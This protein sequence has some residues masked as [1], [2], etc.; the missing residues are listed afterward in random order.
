MKINKLSTLFH[1]NIKTKVFYSEAKLS[2]F[3]SYVLCA[4]MYDCWLLK[5]KIQKIDSRRAIHWVIWACASVCACDRTPLLTRP[6]IL[7]IAPMSTTY[8]G[9]ILLNSTVME[10]RASRPMLI[11]TRESSRSYL[12]ER[13]SQIKPTISPC[14]STSPTLVHTRNYPILP[15]P[16]STRI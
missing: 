14:G 5:K 11:R 15:M 8:R 3:V 4:D 2:R 12:P 1:Q 16:F 9:S 7:A 13:H 10:I 6:V